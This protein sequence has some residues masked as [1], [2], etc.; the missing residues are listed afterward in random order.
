MKAMPIFA[1]VDSG[2]QVADFPVRFGNEAALYCPVVDSCTA[3]IKGSWDQTSANF[4]PLKVYSAPTSGG[5]SPTSLADVVVP[6]GPGSAY[7]A[8]D[9]NLAAVLPYARVVL[10]V[11]QT[12]PRTLCMMAKWD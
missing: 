2:Q 8:L 1:L 7:F 5:L 11:A 4:L 6:V 12:A 10:S 3:A 9:Y